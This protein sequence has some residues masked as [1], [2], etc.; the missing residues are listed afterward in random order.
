LR[1][2]A[3]EADRERKAR[4]RDD[5]KA[6]RAKVEAQQ[7]A[8][9]GGDRQ[10]ENRRLV[11]SRLL[12]DRY[13]AS[14]GPSGALAPARTALGS[15]IRARKKDWPVNP[16][17]GYPSSAEVIKSMKVDSLPWDRLVGEKGK[18]RSPST[19]MRSE[20]PHYDGDCLEVA[21]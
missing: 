5:V 6:A 3:K 8:I 19:A 18:P 1:R 12:A 20:L 10:A 4:K 9:V 17:D 14:C 7:L 13:D 21:A 2:R 11:T 15:R 16:W